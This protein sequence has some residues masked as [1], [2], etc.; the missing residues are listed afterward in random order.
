MKRRDLLGVPALWLAPGSA[1]YA[2][3]ESAKTEGVSGLRIF[4]VRAR[5]AAGDG[6]SL[7]TQPINKTIDECY[8]AGGGVVY[9]P[10]GI[11][12]SGTVELKSNVTLRLEAGAILLGSTNIADY[13]DYPGTAFS[14]RQGYTSG[15]HLIFARDARNVGI[16]GP[17][18]IDGQGPSFWKGGLQPAGSPS[19]RI[20][21]AGCK[22]SGAGISPCAVLGRPSPM[23]ELVGCKGVR[24]EDVR[25][26]NPAGYTLRPVNCEDVFIRGIVIQGPVYGPNTDGIDPTGSHN[27]FI[28]DCL[29]QSGDDAICIKSENPYGEARITRNVT[30]TNCMLT[31]CCNGLKLGTP[32]WGGFEN[33]T[34]SNSVIFND[35]VAANQRI[36]AGIALEMVDGGKFE[37]VVISNIRMQN[38]RTP[39]FI[40]RGN[41]NSR[42]DGTPGT[43][44][45]IRIDNVHATGAIFTSSVTGLPGFDVEDVTLSN[46]HIE[47]DE[48]GQAAW[49]EPVIPEFPKAYPEASMHG[50]L[51]AYGFYCRHVNGLRM[52]GIEF[53]VAREEQRPA[54]VC[55]D[56]VRLDIDGLRPATVGGSQPAVKLIQTRMALLRGCV[57]PAGGTTFLEIQGDRTERIVV[58]GNDP[59]EAK[60]PIVIGPGVPP[61][62][63]LAGAP[64][65]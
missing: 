25:L 51:P 62:A 4:D 37:G 41:R 57:A 2:L 53:G 13:K 24:I 63:V 29:I 15:R 65:L 47:T 14:D 22:W 12:L 8:A 35:P 21:I 48:G 60:D 44:R 38:V 9:L 23:I 40:R 46:I 45:G 43:M 49:V 19:P 33:I 7:D 31:C 30:I 50:N 27:V 39:I 54:I 32:S 16:K 26:E 36:I 56:V 58:T 10:P 1:G 3:A 17:G 11:Y 59:G 5:G 42:P 64:R 61:G 52:R 18:R 20:E 34:F 55:D 6:K 28:S